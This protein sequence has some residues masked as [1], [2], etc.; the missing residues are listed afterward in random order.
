M[1]EFAL[2]KALRITEDFGTFECRKF[3]ERIFSA[4]EFLCL[5]L[6]HHYKRIAERESH[7]AAN[8]E[9]RQLHKL[10]TLGKS[11]EGLF[12]TSSD[13]EVK[14]FARHK[15]KQVSTIFIQNEKALGPTIA[16]EKVI[17]II[18]RCEFEFPHPEPLQAS[19]EELAPALARTFDE[20]WWRRQIRKRQDFILEAVHIRLGLVNKRSGIYASNHGVKR[21]FSQ[22]NR[23]EGLLARLVAENDLGQV[24]S[25][26]D[27][28]KR[29][30]S[31]LTN[32]RN[33][34]MTRLSGF[35]GISAKRGDIGVFVTLTAPSKYHSH[36][37]N[38][39]VP[40]PKYQGHT[41]ADAQAHLNRQW[42]KIRAKF[43]RMGI[44]PYGFRVVEPHHDGCP[45]WHLLLFLPQPQVKPAIEVMRHYAMEIDGDEA[46]ADKHRL[47]VEYIDP[48]KGTAT[49]YIAK[50]IAKNI[51]GVDVG[52]DL[53]GHDAIESATRIRAWASTWNIRQFQQIGGPGVTAWRECR[54]L[55]HSDLKEAVLNSVGDEKL[56]EIVKAADE[57]DWERFVELFGG[58]TVA[59][60]DQPLRAYQV[61][62]ST[63]NKYGEEAK[64]LI[65]LLYRGI[66]KVRT[67]LF[68]WTI[69][70]ITEAEQDSGFTP[71]N[72]SSGGANAPP[73]E[74]CQ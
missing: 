3:R 29:G 64:K 57:G 13:D 12:I 41:P 37:S 54:R 34:L 27:I 8:T 10:L 30:V 62:K 23:N 44:K 40:N 53:H 49:G 55:S 50:Y 58:P 38:P 65:G 28:T 17:A 1:S 35:E 63:L 48:A 2:D 18:E 39:C 6:A 71:L 31:N 32:R 51:D 42:S 52:E 70:P 9:L 66:E 36:L 7:V 47:K 60:K 16:L 25:L 11:F 67:R 59:R 22:W 45:H 21:K 68:E 19:P 72:F 26:L 24:F 43:D 5:P 4:H 73:L 69:R 14:E 46:G 15:A 74:F 56:G 20:Q 61:V 33:E